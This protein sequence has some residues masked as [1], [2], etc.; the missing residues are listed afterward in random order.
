MTFF[1][2]EE[3]FS[4]TAE[5]EVMEFLILPGSDWEFLSTFPRIKEIAKQYNTPIPSS[6]PVERVF[7][8]GSIVLTPRRNRLS[9]K[10]F[11]RLLLM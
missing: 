10:R 9:D 8:L 2:F 4:Y 1:E 5:T 3:E 7:S 6:A 11:E